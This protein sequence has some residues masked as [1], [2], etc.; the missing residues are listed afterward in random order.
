MLGCEAEAIGRPAHLRM[1]GLTMRNALSAVRTASLAVFAGAALLAGCS[2]GATP[3]AGARTVA[4]V[5]VQPVAG[6]TA[7]N[8]PDVASRLREMVSAM[9]FADAQADVTGSTQV[10]VRVDGAVPVSRLQAALEPGPLLFRKVLNTVR[11]TSKGSAPTASG[12][13]A[14]ADPTLDTV[15]A[16]VGNRAWAAAMVLADTPDGSTTS[17]DQLIVNAL[18]PFGRLTPAE[19]AVL[20]A[21]F[22]FY[23]PQ[24]GCAMLNARA[25][26]ATDNPQATV[27]VCDNQS[28]KYLLDVA[29]VSGGDV[30]S[31][32]S[33]ADASSVWAVNIAFSST[34][35]RRWTALTSEAF[36]NV[37]GH[38]VL[39]R[40]A[41]EA[42]HAPVCEIALVQDNKVLTAAAIQAVLSS[43]EHL[44]GSFSQEQA[45][46]LAAQLVL[47]GLPVRIS[48]LSVSE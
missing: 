1:A 34:G 33:S 6:A 16:A 48:V 9:G 36:N 42:G 25:R 11:D 24:I 14:S 43:D 26:G 46:T 21:A 3:P 10:T 15:R 27:V 47:A 29:K 22:Q 37:G 32:S 39:T 40:P 41:V 8:L 19:V 18:A 7:P 44:S 28:T 45:M 13:A 23:V 4:V 20:P 38:C 35:T 31:A 12:G 30:G 17:A 5:D 2:A